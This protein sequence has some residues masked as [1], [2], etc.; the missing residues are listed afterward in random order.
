MKSI[1]VKQNCY[2]VVEVDYTF[3]GEHTIKFTTIIV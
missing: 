1:E 3:G 2:K